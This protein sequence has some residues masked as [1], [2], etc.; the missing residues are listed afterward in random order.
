VEVAAQPQPARAFVH[1][2]AHPH[3][4]VP[5]LTG[6][7]F[8]WV[9]WYHGAAAT[10]STSPAPAHAVGGA[11]VDAGGGTAAFSIGQD[12]IRARGAA[13]ARSATTLQPRH[14]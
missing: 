2:G 9:L 12:R 11:G 5:I 7:R 6:E 10:A 3:R 14:G 4:T 8:N 13:R 1:L